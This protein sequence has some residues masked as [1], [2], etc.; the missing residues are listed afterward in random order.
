MVAAWRLREASLPL[1]CHCLAT[2][3]YDGKQACLE[4]TDLRHTYLMPAG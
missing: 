3:C 1:S 2:L 4:G